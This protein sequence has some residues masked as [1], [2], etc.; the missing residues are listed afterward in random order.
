MLRNEEQNVQTLTSFNEFLNHIKIPP[1]ENFAVDLSFEKICNDAA[2]VIAECIQNGFCGKLIHLDLSNS[3]LEQNGAEAIAHALLKCPPGFR[4][5]LNNNHLGATAIVAFAWVLSQPNCSENLTLFIHDGN[6]ELK[7]VLELISALKHAP[8]GLTIRFNVDIYQ[9]GIINTNSTLIANLAQFIGSSNGPKNLTL[10]LRGFVEEGLLAPVITALTWPTCKPGLSLIL[11]LSMMAIQDCKAL[12][13]ALESGKTRADLRIY[14]A[15][16]EV[17]FINKNTLYSKTDT[18][19]K[20][21]AKLSD[22]VRLE[23][24]PKQ[25][26]FHPRKRKRKEK[27]VKS[28]FPLYEAPKPGGL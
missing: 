11:D 20:L 22:L 28:P 8:G 23:N 14:F 10:D 5:L 18:I 2:L 7:P 21:T 12:K 1:T 25:V 24:L 15:T 9:D 6:V 19:T 3:N 16:E 26:F 27:K 13:V 4:L 17:D